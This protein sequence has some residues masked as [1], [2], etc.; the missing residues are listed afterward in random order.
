MMSLLLEEG[1]G[2]S[3]KDHVASHKRQCFHCCC[4]AIV[5]VCVNVPLTFKLYQ[6]YERGLK[7]DKGNQD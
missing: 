1:L 3:E 5:Q 6:A 2:M 7:T 4:E